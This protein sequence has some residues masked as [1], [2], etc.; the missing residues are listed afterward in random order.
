[1]KYLYLLPI[2]ILSI[3]VNA[4]FDLKVIEKQ[5]THLLLCNWPDTSNIEV[6]RIQVSKD[7]KTWKTIATTRD[8]L[9][10]TYFV[11]EYKPEQ[12]FNY[13]RIEAI[14]VDYQSKISEV[15]AGI[16]VN[17]TLKLDSIIIFD[18]SGMIYR[19]PPIDRSYYMWDNN[20]IIKIER[21]I[22]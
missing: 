20:F 21:C 17:K 15:V 16:S 3:S 12:I 19:E 18:A 7:L 2:L 8:K 9:N 5:D 10:D 1:M 14:N 22:E 11:T 4:Q 13:Y 6:Y